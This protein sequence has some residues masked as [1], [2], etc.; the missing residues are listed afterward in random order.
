MQ[1][2]SCDGFKSECPKKLNENIIFHEQDCSNTWSINP[3]SIDLIFTSNFFEH[4]PNK[5]SLR[6]TIEEIRKALKPN[7]LLIAMGPNISVLKGSYWDFGIIMF[8]Y[9]MRLFVNFYKLMIF[10][11]SNHIPASFLTT[12]FGVNSILCF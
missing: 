12:W 7:G 4:L 9:Q 2:S 8:H 11:L 5:E 10:Q 1:E 3:S 6:S